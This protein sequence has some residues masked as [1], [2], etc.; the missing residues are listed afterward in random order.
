MVK[1][2]V[3]N[4]KGEIS[5]QSKV[6]QGTVVSVSIP[7]SRVEPGINSPSSDLASS[8]S[9]LQALCVN[10]T[11]YM[12]GSKLEPTTLLGESLRLYI[13]KWFQLGLATDLYHADF[14]IVDE[15]ALEELIPTFRGS[16]P[17]LRI[18]VLRTPSIA[19][20]SPQ[21]EADDIL[22]PFGPC[23][24]A[25]GLLNAWARIPAGT[26]VLSRSLSV[27]PIALSQSFD[28]LSERGL[29]GFDQ[30]AASF[31]ADAESRGEGS[32]PSE[33]NQGSS[34]EV[35]PSPSSDPPKALA[36]R[37]R[38]PRILCVDDNPLNLKLL[39]AYLKKLGYLNARCAENGLEAA[40]IYDSSE[41]GFDLI[42]MGE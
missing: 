8:I 4:L 36:T 39:Q 21:I 25:K 27:G 15:T 16:T 17:V 20:T 41:S 11:V 19:R 3:Q 24:L 34:K 38:Q 32:R 31:Y 22:K 26:R 35:H 13:T 7:V 10:R 6:G 12:H 42:F 28:L 23:R 30:P 5:L 1:K 29:Y 9:L 14:V 2:I 33:S 40:N 18:V 37:R